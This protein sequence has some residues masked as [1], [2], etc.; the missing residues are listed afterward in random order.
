[1]LEI[2]KDTLIGDII[3]TYP[4]AE[5]IIEKYFGRGCFTCPGV[6]MESV[7]F[8]AMM[9]QQDPEVIL[10]ELHEAAARAGSPL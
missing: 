8:G 1:M 5:G 9:H 7:A 4:W 10:K 2:T 6:K 3:S